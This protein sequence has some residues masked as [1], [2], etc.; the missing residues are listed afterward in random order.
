M[1]TGIVEEV[2]TVAEAAKNRLRITGGLVM[3]SLAVSDS[4]A[5]N[6]VCLTVVERT[7]DVFT[8]DVVEETLSRTNLGALQAGDIVNLERAL[9]PSSRM[10]G[11]I[12]QGHVD[13]TG[14][15][16]RMSGSPE[17]RVL[18]VTL[19][20]ELM[21]YVVE[22]GFIALDGISLTVAETGATEF[23]VAVIPYTSEHTSLKARAHGDRVNIEI[24]ILAKYVERLTSFE[25]RG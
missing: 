13:G 10:G 19:R 20:P 21:R 25:A 7:G 24:D 4:I 2:G 15:V 1:F 17:E 14:V 12:V 9:T 23:S 22:K 8:V 5:L 18:W 11:H 16:D 3:E 6:G